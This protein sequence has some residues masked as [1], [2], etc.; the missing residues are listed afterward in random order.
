LVNAAY[1]ARTFAGTG[2]NSDLDLRIITNC[3][4]RKKKRN[5][6]DDAASLG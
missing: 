5:L 2:W 6:K 3:Q 1:I 4:L